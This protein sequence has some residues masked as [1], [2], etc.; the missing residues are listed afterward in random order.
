MPSR[1][2]TACATKGWLDFRRGMCRWENELGHIGT[3]REVNAKLGIVAGLEII[4]RNAFADLARGGADDR[5]GVGVVVRLTAEDLAADGAL[6]HLVGVTGQ[7]ALDHVPEQIR[8]ALAVLEQRMGQNPFELLAD[9]LALRASVA[10]PWIQNGSVFIHA[11]AKRGG[12]SGGAPFGFYH[13]TGMRRLR[14]VASRERAGPG[15]PPHTNGSIRR[16]K[17]P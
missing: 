14:R 3:G 5:V 10:R 1:S 2:V 15:E 13:P 17:R 4:L 16:I 8:V 12:R 6:L 7:G 11:A 9:G